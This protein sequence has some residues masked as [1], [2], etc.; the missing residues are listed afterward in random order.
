MVSE[1]KLVRMN[2]VTYCGLKYRSDNELSRY[3]LLL[4]V[5]VLILA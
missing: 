2:C 1:V 5:L 4:V 3:S